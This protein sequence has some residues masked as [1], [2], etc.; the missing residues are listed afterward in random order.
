MTLTHKHTH[1]ASCLRGKIGGSKGLGTWVFVFLEKS[2]IALKIR[3]NNIWDITVSERLTRHR[4]VI[5]STL[6][7]DTLQEM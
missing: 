1:R 7:R 3:D 4:K 6:K 5:Q 2:E